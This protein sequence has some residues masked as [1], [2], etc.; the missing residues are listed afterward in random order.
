[1]FMVAGFFR[2]SIG[3]GMREVDSPQFTVESLEKEK[4]GREAKMGS[5]Y[6]SDAPRASETGNGI[7]QPRLLL[8]RASSK[9]RMTLRA[10]CGLTARSARPSRA[11]RTLT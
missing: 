7:R 1:M 10:C 4:M 9:I 3:V 11:A 6:D 2:E 8:S 5:R